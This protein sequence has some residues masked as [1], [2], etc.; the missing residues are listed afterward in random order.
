MDDLSHVHLSRRCA[1][2]GAC[3][4]NVSGFSCLQSPCFA[5]SLLSLTR[6]LM[7]VLRRSLRSF[8]S[9]LHSRYIFNA[10][11]YAESLAS[12]SVCVVGQIDCAHKV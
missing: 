2:I 3:D 12:L 11:Q 9:G 10:M 8:A 7:Y 1:R 5:L 6:V 4:G